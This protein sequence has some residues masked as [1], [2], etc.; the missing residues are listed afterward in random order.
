MCKST[1]FSHEAGLKEWY[2]L[3]SAH[4]CMMRT[5]PKSL[6]STFETCLCSLPSRYTKCICEIVHRNTRV[7]L[8]DMCAGW[9]VLKLKWKHA[10]QARL[11]QGRSHRSQRAWCLAASISGLGN[12]FSPMKWLSNI[13]NNRSASFSQLVRD[14]QWLAIKKDEWSRAYV[15]GKVGNKL[16]SAC[17]SELARRESSLI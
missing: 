5:G 3:G 7:H 8:A 12:W 11:P 6:P 9:M 16:R 14:K 10:R 4:L 2:L 15:H 1:G 13:R 17:F